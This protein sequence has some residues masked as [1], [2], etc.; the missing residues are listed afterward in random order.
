MLAVTAACTAVGVDVPIGLPSTGRR[1]CDTAAAARLGPSRSSVFPAPVRAVL[2]ARGYTAACAASRA[3]TGAAIS[4]QTWNIVPKIGQWDA[5]AVP[6][7]VIEVHPELSF[8]AL[9]PGTAFAPKKTA[10]GAAQRI[11][12]LARV[13]PLDRAL[14]D[15]PAGAGL[16]D[17]LDALAAAWSAARWSTGHAEVLG[18]EL[19]A[20]GRPM[21]MAV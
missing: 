19:D 12:A 13:L 7:H 10:R 3:T 2:A 21:R 17:I 18:G 9:T 1:P 4:R 20:R 14:A 5:V 11:A 8:R 6:P 15:P 16:D